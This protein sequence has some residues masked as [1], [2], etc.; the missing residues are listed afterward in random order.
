MCERWRH[1]FAAFIEDMGRRPSPEHSINRINNDGP[2]APDNCEWATRKVQ[3]SNRRGNH[4]IDFR[5]ERLTVTEWAGRIGMSARALLSR[6]EYGWTVEES[7]TTPPDRIGNR[8]GLP[9]LTLNGVTR[10]R[11]EW[12]RKLGMRSGSLKERLE[13]WPVEQAL[14]EPKRRH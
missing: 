4:I 6:L 13:R 12:A 7:L 14:T 9:R 2:Y 3:S 10:T 5:G 1:S 8:H 11:A